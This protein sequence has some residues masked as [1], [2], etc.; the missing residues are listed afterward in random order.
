MTKSTHYLIKWAALGREFRS[1][2]KERVPKWSFVQRL[3]DASQPVLQVNRD[4]ALRLLEA[5]NQILAPLKDPFTMR[6][7]SHRWLT[8]EREEAYS[9]WLAWIV[10]Q[11]A[12]PAKI[13]PLFCGNNAADLTAQCAG[14]LKVPRET[15]FLTT[16]ENVRRTDIEISFGDTKAILLEI[17]MI[18]AETIDPAQMQDLSHYGADFMKRCLLVPSGKEESGPSGFDLVLWR[19]ICLRLR[20]M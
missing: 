3:I 6:L 5:S 10:E 17:K 11:L 12:T 7:G 16:T 18:D 15:R 9:D 1:A 19:D 8:E 13:I 14:P 20:R 4:A 2:T